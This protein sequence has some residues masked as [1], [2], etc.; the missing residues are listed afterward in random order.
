MSPLGLRKSGSERADKMADK[1]CFCD[2]IIAINA[3]NQ[4][5]ERADKKEDDLLYMLTAV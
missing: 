3:M 2:E 4:W 5:I 1:R